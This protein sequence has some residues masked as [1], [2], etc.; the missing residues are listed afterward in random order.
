MRVVA[1]E[2]GEAVDMRRSPWSDRGDQPTVFSWRC[3]CACARRCRPPE[4]GGNVPWQPAAGPGVGC[5]SPSG[6]ETFPAGTD[7]EGPYDRSLAW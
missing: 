7:G 3:V 1:T 6:G 2:T 4:R 5:W